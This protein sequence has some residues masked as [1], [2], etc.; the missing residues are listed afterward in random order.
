MIPNFDILAR[1]LNERRERLGLS[2]SAVAK[3]TGL[4]LR[5]VQRIMAG[6][7]SEPK[8]KSIA[9]I[10]D[11]VG[12]AIQFAE[13]DVHAVRRRQAEQMASRIVA[14]VQGTSAL[15][16]QGV[17]TSAIQDLR[18]QTINELLG[19]SNRRLWGN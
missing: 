6:E 16:A 7:E 11:V 3:R 10:A 8:F 2:C 13:E 4:S 14:M 9:A 12:M 19:G 15:E 5:S 1:R 18:E 17:S